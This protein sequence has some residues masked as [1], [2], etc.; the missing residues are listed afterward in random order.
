MMRDVDL[1]KQTS[2]ID[3]FQEAVHNSSPGTKIIYHRGE[4]LAGSRLARMALKAFEA[5]H[6][7]LVQ[8]RDARGGNGFFEF[9][10]VKKRDPKP[11]LARNWA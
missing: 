8:R 9:I 7:E 11:A 10:A 5:G 1:T 4:F 6:V 2:P 3:A